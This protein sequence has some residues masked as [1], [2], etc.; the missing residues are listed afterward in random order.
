MLTRNILSCYNM[1]IVSI[2]MNKVNYGSKIR[3]YRKRA[4]VNQ[5]TL[6][7][8]IGASPGALS[9]IENGSINPT[10]ETLIKISDRLKLTKDE[11]LDLLGFSFDRLTSE[12]SIREVYK[13]SFAA[14]ELR[15][16]VDLGVAAKVNKDN[17]GFYLE[18]QKSN[19][20]HTFEII[21]NTKASIEAARKFSS[22]ANFKFKVSNNIS[23]T[24][25]MLLFENKVAFINWIDSSRSIVI[26]DSDYYINMVN[27][28]NM[29]WKLL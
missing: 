7:T 10:K 5:L 28:F 8:D 6:E 24:S 17:A 29:I 11:T 27:H 18:A 20:S 13:Q 4:E 9:R 22:K 2:S 12:A 14:S 3:Y 19:Q 26:D 1:D 21:K 23:S 15:S 16:Y 25:D